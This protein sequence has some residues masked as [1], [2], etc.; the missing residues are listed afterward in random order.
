MVGGEKRPRES[1]GDLVRP[2]GLLNDR[3]RGPLPLNR[4][5]GIAGMN[6]EREVPVGEAP[7]DRQC[8]SIDTFSLLS[9]RPG[10]TARGSV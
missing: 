7:A 6:D 3:N 4:V 8:G 1:V 5:G 2:R 9:I 10:E